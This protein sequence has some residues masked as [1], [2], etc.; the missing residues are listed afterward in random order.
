M[1]LVIGS[2][3]PTVSYGN[4]PQWTLGVT[5]IHPPA[6]AG[7]PPTIEIGLPANVPSPF[8]INVP[9][10]NDPNN[11]NPPQPNNYPGNPGP[12]SRFN[13]RDY[14]WLVRHFSVLN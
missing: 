6:A 4:T 2:G 12:R 13:P 7:D 10:E 5:K 8:L 1:Q 3:D 14:P 11:P 9:Y